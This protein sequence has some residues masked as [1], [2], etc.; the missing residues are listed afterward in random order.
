M[1]YLD[2]ELGNVLPLLLETSYWIFDIL[3]HYR[4]Q[5]KR[6]HVTVSSADRSFVVPE[7]R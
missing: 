3:E 2:I 6:N 7:S 1:Y 4:I 5:T